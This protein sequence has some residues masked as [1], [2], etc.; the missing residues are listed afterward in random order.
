[1]LRRIVFCWAVISC[2]VLASMGQTGGRSV[3]NFLDYSNSNRVSALGGGLISVRDDD[4]SMLFNNPSAISPDH[5][6]S[7]VANITDYFSNAAYGSMMYSHTFNKVGSMAFGVQFATYG[8]FEGR[9]NV[10][11]E[12]GSFTAGDYAIY[13]G[14][15][16]RLDSC[17]S[18]G[19]A[20]KLVYSGY[21]SYHSFGFATDVAASYY[22]AKR[23][24][25]LTLMVKNLGSQLKPYTTGR[26]EP[27]PFDLQF[28][29]SQRLAHLPV[30]YHISLHSLYRWNMIDVRSYEPFLERDAMTGELHYPNKAA[31][32]FDNFFRHINVG[33]EIIP[34]KYLSLFVSYNHQR[35]QEMK[36]PQGKSLAGFSY[37]FMVNIHSIRIGFSRS[38]F[39]A[40]ATPNY[41]TV[42]ANISELSQLSKE[43]KIKKLER[44]N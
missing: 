22:N 23:R 16:R 1:M 25:S 24:L 36:I 11:N 38:H 10:G 12:T 17:F 6:T 28:A 18:I 5:H 7:L 34:V 19:A 9:D 26:Y 41:F 29:L 44:V 13:W 37:G 3:Y 15:G 20:L 4:P 35:H 30:R 27:L 8:K 43:K 40:G 42:A 39:A 21:E 14:W 2:F 32:F 31:R 33:I